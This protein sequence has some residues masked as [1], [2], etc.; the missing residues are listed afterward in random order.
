MQGR[1][2]RYVIKFVGNMDKAV[3][4]YRD[5]VGLTLKFESGLERVRNR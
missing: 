4:F 5:V 3:K 1:Q 2:L